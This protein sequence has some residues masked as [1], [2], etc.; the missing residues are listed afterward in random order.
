[1]ASSSGSHFFLPFAVND[2]I[3]IISADTRIL[4]ERF[5][6]VTEFALKD[7]AAFTVQFAAAEIEDALVIDATPGCVLDAA[8][9][10]SA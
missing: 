8:A 2:V 5:A 1:M 6:I 7:P 3:G 4:P 10:R 9:V